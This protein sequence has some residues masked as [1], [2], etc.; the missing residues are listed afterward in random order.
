MPGSFRRSASRANVA[1]GAVSVRNVMMAEGE[2]LV[3]N[4]QPLAE[5]L[6]RVL[7]V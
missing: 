5:E 2:L 3:A 4:F 1:L 6:C 7:V